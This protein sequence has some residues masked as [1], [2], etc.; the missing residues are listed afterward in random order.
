M[1]ANIQV[2]GKSMEIHLFVP[3]CFPFQNCHPRR[4]RC[5][6]VQSGKRSPRQGQELRRGEVQRRLLPGEQQAGE[7]RDQGH[8]C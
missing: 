7:R 1:R 6:Q 5:R 3:Q 2:L 8:V 4:D